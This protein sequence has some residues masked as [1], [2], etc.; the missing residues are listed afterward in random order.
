MEA[1][2]SL[3]IVIQ[4]EGAYAKILVQGI[5]RLFFVTKKAAL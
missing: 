4:T 1:V 2:L 5:V 3:G